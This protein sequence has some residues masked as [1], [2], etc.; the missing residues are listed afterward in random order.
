MRA[1]RALVLAAGMRLQYRT[2]RCAADCFQAVFVMGTPEARPLRLSAACAG[3]TPAGVSAGDFGSLAASA[4]ADVCAR[5]RIDVVLPSDGESTRWLAQNRAAL[6]ARCY[7]TPTVPVFDMLDDKHRFGDLCGRIGIPVPPMTLAEDAEQA[8]AAIRT[9]A[10]RLPAVIKP[11]RLWGSS[12]VAR[13]DH[14]N[15][16]EVLAAV[17]YAPILIQEFIDGRDLSVFLLCQAGAASAA[18]VY[19]RSRESVDFIR[20]DGLVALAQRIAG[21]VDFDG[22]IGFDVREQPDGALFFLECNPRFWYSMDAAR[23]AGLNFVA[24]GLE[25]APPAKLR[26]LH[27]VRVPQ[28]RALLHHR[29]WKAD[30]ALARLGRECVADLAAHAAMAAH[31]AFGRDRNARGKAV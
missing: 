20:H 31:S 23:R 4:V 12:G 2:V 11:L 29:P 14:A 9:G 6:P 10:V 1:E 7:P 5:L 21:H 24:L 30:V 16:T 22:V 26:V 25:T 17:G 8:A 15:A 27:D 13:I 19:Q 28:L 18:V 3:F